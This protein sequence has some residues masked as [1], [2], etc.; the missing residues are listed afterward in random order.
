[1]DERK[2][3]KLQMR[4]REISDVDRLPRELRKIRTKEMT[5]DDYIEIEPWERD[6]NSRIPDEVRRDMRSRRFERMED[7]DDLKRELQTRIMD[8]E[9]DE[10]GDHFLGQ[11]SFVFSELRERYMTEAEEIRDPSELKKRI[12]DLDAL[13]AVFHGG[14]NRKRWR[15]PSRR[16]YRDEF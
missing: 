15:D 5:E 7:L 10:I 12:D 6:M 8:L 13:S 14:R 16:H 3:H 9:D 2:R 4:L 11:N 1:M